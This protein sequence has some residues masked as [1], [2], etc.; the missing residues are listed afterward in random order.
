[1]TIPDDLR[2]SL[3][4]PAN[5]KITLKGCEVAWVKLFAPDELAM[6]MFTIYK[7]DGLHKD[8]F[9]GIDLVKECESYDPNGIMVWFSALK[10]YGQWDGDHHKIIVFPNVSWSNIAA[11]PAPYF[12]AQWVPHFV[13]HRYL[14]PR[15]AQ[16]KRPTGRKKP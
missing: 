1:V 9:G 13:P 12:N 8:R 15:P 14:R 4:T 5:R 7:K 6:R 10:V 16:A 3:A 2:E 11:N